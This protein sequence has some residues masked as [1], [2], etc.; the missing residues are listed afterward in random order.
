MGSM[1]GLSSK[2]VKRRGAD[3]PM[4][5]GRWGRGGE[6]MRPR[7]LGLLINFI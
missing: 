7:A 6:H 2:E 3:S 4:R 5:G 1:M